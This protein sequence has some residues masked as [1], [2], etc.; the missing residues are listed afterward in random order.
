MNAAKK[1]ILLFIYITSSLVI[2]TCTACKQQKLFTTEGKSNDHIALLKK[3]DYIISNDDKISLSIWDNEELSIGSVYGIYNSNEVYGKW[4]LVDKTGYAPLPKIGKVKLQGL[5]IQQANDTVVNLY[6]QFIL[7]PILVLRVLNREVTVL[8]EVKNSGVINLEKE[9]NTLTSILGK[10]GGLD[11]FADA[12]Q[13]KVIRG[14]DEEKKEY[15]IDLTKL[16]TIEQENIYLISGDIIYVPPLKKKA[17]QKES[18]AIVPI[19]SLISSLA[20]IT[21]LFLK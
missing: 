7:N 4:V 6:K 21:S 15:T 16:S 19:V 10:T 2:F 11:Y 12:S 13:I 17:Y 9:H 14:K 8:G 18:P 1:Y 3:Q 20:I 5:T